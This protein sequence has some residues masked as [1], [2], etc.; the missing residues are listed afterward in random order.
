MVGKYLAYQWRHSTTDNSCA[1]QNELTL[2]CVITLVILPHIH[3]HDEW[4]ANQMR[5]CVDVTANLRCAV[6]KRF[7]YCSPQTEICQF[8]M[9]TQRELDT[10]DV[11]YMHQVSFTCTRC[12][13]H[14]PGVLYM[15]HV[16]FMHQVSFTC[17]RCPLHAPGILCSPQVCGKPV[18]RRTR[19]AQRINGVL[20]YTK[21]TI[22]HTDTLS[23][24]QA[25]L[26]NLVYIPWS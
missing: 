12:L 2:L 17:T 20:V 10:S 4:F 8:F 26:G 7:A 19:M 21:L 23:H 22:M 14:A 5:V 11:L 16:S 13:L 24:D 25:Y 18:T 1:C 3:E 6:C 15:H 9:G